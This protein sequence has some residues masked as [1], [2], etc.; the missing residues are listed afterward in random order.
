MSLKNDVQIRRRFQRS[1]RL[2][3][4]LDDPLALQGF[5][6]PPTFAHALTTLSQQ[7]KDAGHAAFTWTGPFG[8]G[9]SSL[10]VVMSALL[11]APGVKRRRAMSAVGGPAKA[12]VDAL[13]PG[14]RG[15]RS[16]AVVGR[17]QDCA[18]LI[19][20]ALRRDRLI[21]QPIDTQSDG[22]EALLETLVRI[23]K[24][25]KHAGLVIFIDEM[26]KVL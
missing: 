23:A 4:D 3:T 7:V 16:L 17:K 22:G 18:V 6:C 5:I 15:Y 24:R 13:K 21:R 10:A 26:G 1:I 11:G 19:A 25:P 12:I 9:K 8:G 2:D 20:H 14:R